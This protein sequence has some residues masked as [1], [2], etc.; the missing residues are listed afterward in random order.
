MLYCVHVYGS[1][2]PGTLS[3]HEHMYAC[4]YLLYCS[5][6]RPLLLLKEDDRITSFGALETW[7]PKRSK[8]G[9]GFK[10]VFFNQIPLCL[11]LLYRRF[12]C[13]VD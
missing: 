6:Y 3:G 7:T 5:I 8:S 12:S 2:S 9:Y 1:H 4:A 10:V 13:R 11:Y